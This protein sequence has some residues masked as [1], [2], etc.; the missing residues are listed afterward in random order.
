MLNV[1]QATGRWMLYA[2]LFEWMGLVPA[3]KKFYQR[4][5]QFKDLKDAQETLGGSRAQ[6]FQF[7]LPEDLERI[8]KLV[9]MGVMTMENK[10]VKLAQMNQFAQT[11]MPFPF[12]K[13]LEMARKQWVE[14][15]NQEPDSV[16]FSDD[17][18][19]A[20]TQFQQQ[21]MMQQSQMSQGMG[22]GAPGSPPSMP[23]PGI[24][25]KGL[26]G[27][28]GRPAPQSGQGANVP[29]GQPVAGNIIGPRYGQ[30]RPAMPARGPGVS[31]MDMNGRPNG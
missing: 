21:A 15:G 19:K 12:F 1:Q 16:L 11:W 18:Q 20:Y 7:V 31:P 5:Y 10:G 22:P 9:P 6:T 3:M 29:G 30:P 17:E 25:G 8:A 14:G 28:D 27:P 2:R 26:L 24:P 13:K 23:P 4:I